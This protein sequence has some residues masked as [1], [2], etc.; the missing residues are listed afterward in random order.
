MSTPQMLAGQNLISKLLA[1]AGARDRIVYAQCRVGNKTEVT[2]EVV[3]EMQA[4]DHAEVDAAKA[5]EAWLAVFYE[6]YPERKP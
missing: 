2:M 4:L 6:R 1:C 3:T 5:A